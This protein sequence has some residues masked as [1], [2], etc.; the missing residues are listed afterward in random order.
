LRGRGL[1]IALVPGPQV[2]RRGRAGDRG[3]EPR[4]RAAAAAR[5][6][7]QPAGVERRLAEGGD[8][9]REGDR[10]RVVGQLTEVEQVPDLLEGAAARE[11]DRVVA[12][13]EEA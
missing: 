11:R 5:E 10:G 6:V 12:G 9:T 1:R 13:V 8:A 2:E 4:H 7:A 3:L